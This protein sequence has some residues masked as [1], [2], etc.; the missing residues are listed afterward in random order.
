MEAAIDLRFLGKG[1]NGIFNLGF[2]VNHH[3]IV[4]GPNM[5]TLKNKYFIIFFCSFAYL[6][7][8]GLKSDDLFAIKH[9]TTNNHNTSIYERIWLEYEI[10]TRKIPIRTKFNTTEEIRLLNTRPD[11]LYM[12]EGGA[13][14]IYYFSF[15]GCCT[16]GGR[17]IIDV[18]I[19]VF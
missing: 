16:H 3:Q 15:L 17:R 5:F 2:Y 7:K 12:E 1:L 13:R 4:N 11:G 9:N 6:K 10:H 18:F 19:Y 8:F 14:R